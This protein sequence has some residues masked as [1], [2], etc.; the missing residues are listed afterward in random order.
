LNK[1]V[2]AGG[3]IFVV[4]LMC[5]PIAAADLADKYYGDGINFSIR[6]DY[7]DALTAYDKAVFI[8]PGYADAWL[9][10]GVVL[11]NL[12]RFSEAVASY[13]TVLSLRPADAEAWNNRGI[14]LR[15]LG[16]YADAVASYDKA[17]AIRP[18]YTEAWL[19]R[20]V[21]L[22][23]LG[24]YEEAIVSYDKV[25]SFQPNHTTALE[26][27]EIA[28][29]KEKGLNPAA[30]GMLIL[31]VIIIAGVVLWYMKPQNLFGKKSSHKRTPQVIVEE[32]SEEKLHYGTVPEESR[33]HTLANLCRVMNEYGLP[34]LDDREKVSALLEEFSSGDYKNE[35][36]ILI[37]ALKDNIPQEL[38]KLHKGFHWINTSA[39]LRKQ[40]MEDHAIPEDLA[41]WAIETWAKALET[42]K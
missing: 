24:R 30:L 38:L 10:R 33:L 31:T 37:L 34:I 2:I 35:R 1:F 27:R 25:L 42:E 20:G 23:Y 8:R 36:K 41:R 39:R 11:E 12:G 13:D 3:I 28:L 5:P 26:D 16:R 29:T 14:A 22:D 7:V 32:K 18:D 6:G 17:I 19:N 40:L 9:N 15:K 21:A 4:L